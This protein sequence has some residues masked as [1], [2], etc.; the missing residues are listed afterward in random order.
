MSRAAL[1]QADIAANAA[2]LAVN[3]AADLARRQAMIQNRN[4]DG[5]GFNMP[6]VNTGTTQQLNQNVADCAGL[7]VQL[8][9]NAQTKRAALNSAEDGSA[10]QEPSLNE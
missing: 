8:A 3:Q 2:N 5:N 6:Q 9:I 4:S 1:E 10:A 7:A